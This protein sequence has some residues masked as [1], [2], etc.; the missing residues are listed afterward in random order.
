MNNLL[1]VKN[2]ILKPL[3][4]NELKEKLNKKVVLKYVSQM[5]IDQNVSITESDFKIKLQL[6][7][8]ECSNLTNNQF[9][10]QCKVL[11]RRDLYNKIPP[12]F[13]FKD[14]HADGNKPSFLS[15]YRHL[16]DK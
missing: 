8:D 10:D 5:R 12:A 9:I 15:Q 4:E 11:L 3:E 14:P 6:I 13:R 7:F 1:E 16:L 2:D